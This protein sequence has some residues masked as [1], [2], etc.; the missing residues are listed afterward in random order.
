[1][2][3]IHHLLRGLADK[4]PVFHNEADFQFALAS[5]IREKCRQPVRLEWKPFPMAGDVPKGEFQRL[6]AHLIS[7][8]AKR[9]LTTFANLDCVL[10]GLPDEARNDP[11][12]WGNCCH[13]PQSRSWLA[14]GWQVAEV[15]VVEE[16]VLFRHSRIYVD[17]WLPRLGMAIELKYRTRGL[18][19]VE[20]SS[21]LD[22]PCERFSLADQNAQ[23]HGRYDFLR[24]MT[25][26]EWVVA[27]RSDADRGMAV[28]LTNDPQYWDPANK[29]RVDK[30]F[31]L[32][33]GRNLLR[34]PHRMDWAERTKPGTKKGRECPI[35]LGDSYALDWRDY[36]SVETPENAK[37]RAFRYLAVEVPPVSAGATGRESPTNRPGCSPSS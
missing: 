15:D 29:D 33:D 34:G 36:S 17:L 16:T 14:A 3:T 20:R 13:Q 28:L 4:R 12:W 32:C 27:D 21:D 2:L 11:K 23:D 26:L 31:H 1:M 25:R 5:Y 10:G 24:D 8:R 6:G 19:C 35:V 7:L 30:A 9:W 18:K 37:Y 22:P